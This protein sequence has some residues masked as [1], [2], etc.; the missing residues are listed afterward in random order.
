M[1]DKSIVA[2]R[3]HEGLATAA[4]KARVQALREHRSMSDEPFPREATRAAAGAAAE[5]LRRRIGPGD[6][7]LGGL[8]PRPGRVEPGR[9]EPRERVRF[10][11]S[12]AD[13]G[14]PE[15]SQRPWLQVP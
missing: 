1:S 4:A 2:R 8:A 3:I 14:V 5:E 13:S 12:G 9:V 6:L 7:E 15:T 11:G 10:V